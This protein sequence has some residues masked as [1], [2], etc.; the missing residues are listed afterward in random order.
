MDQ[1][2]NNTLSITDMNQSL[3]PKNIKTREEWWES[4]ST[5]A[6][7]PV[8]VRS[9]FRGN[10]KERRGKGRGVRSG[11]E[12]KGWKGGRTD[13]KEEFTSPLWYLLSVFCASCVSACPVGV[14]SCGVLLPL[15]GARWFGSQIIHDSGDAWDLLDLIDHLQHHLGK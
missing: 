1:K 13:E 14:T 6:R 4:G 5:F 8:T 15:C 10:V 12:E 2:N 3:S 9:A 11:E 7:A